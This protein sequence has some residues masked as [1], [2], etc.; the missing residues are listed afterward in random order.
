MPA[1][2]NTLCGVPKHAFP[3]LVAVV[4]LVTIIVSLSLRLS[5]DPGWSYSRS[6]LPFLSDT[7]VEARGR[8]VFGVGM[9]LTAMGLALVMWLLWKALQRVERR[10]NGTAAHRA[11][12]GSS[13]LRVLN[14]T[15]AVLGLFSGLMLA[16]LSIVSLDVSNDAHNVFA[17]LFFV[18]GTMQL[19]AMVFFVWTESSLRKA[20]G[21]PPADGATR[22]SL[23]AKTVLLVLVCVALLVSL[24]VSIVG[25]SRPGEYSNHATPRGSLMTVAVPAVQ[26]TFTLL[27][28]ANMALYAAD[29]YRGREHL[30]EMAW[31]RRKDVHSGPREGLN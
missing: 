10:L 7:G 30:K 6:G 5:L 15:Q 16:L 2:N 4:A 9:T 25:F 28:L 22:L 23:R 8:A 1:T 29:I 18:A 13:L 31:D 26:Y 20:R 11:S 3:P 21:I 19:L 12:P 27:F 14:T 24:V 17:L